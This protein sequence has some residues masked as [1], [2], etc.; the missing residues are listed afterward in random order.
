MKKKFISFVLPAYREEKNIPLIYETLTNECKKLSDYDYEIIF[1]NDGSPDKTRDVIQSICLQDKKVKWVNLSRNFGKEI[2]LTAGVSH[3]WGDAVITLDVDGQHPVEKITDFICER[4]QWYDVVYNRRPQ[5]ADASWLKKIT[6]KWFYRIFNA[7]SDVRIESGTTDYR[8]IDRKIVEIFKQYPE[9]NRM[10]RAIIDMIGGKRKALEFDALPNPEWRKPSYN[11]GKLMQLAIDSITSFSV[12]PL[13]LVWTFWV[14][15]TLLSG[16]AAVFVVTHIL[17]GNA[18]WFTNLWFFTLVNTFF[19]GVVMMALGLIA[20]YIA[21]IHKEVL[22]RP[23]Y[24]TQETT[25]L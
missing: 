15:I 4:E 25:N 7:I 21:N 9:Q 5:I 11:Y 10:Y 18:W 3:A 2:A 17:I 16:L 13:K 14:I 23:L 20:I 24:I 6:S 8:L 12:W 1:V 19:M 22:D